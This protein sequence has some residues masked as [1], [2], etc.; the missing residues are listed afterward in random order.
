MNNINPIFE[1]LSGVDERHVP[2][3]TKK[4]PSKK[5]KIALI[6]VAAAAALSLIIGAS[7]PRSKHYGKSPVFY[8]PGENDVVW[9]Y[10]TPQKFTYPD[11]FVFEDWL[12][13]GE[14]ET[15]DDIPEMFGITP[16]V[17]DNFTIGDK[18]GNRMYYNAFDTGL[19]QSLS[20]D[21]YLYDK[22]LGDVTIHLESIYYS[23]V[24]FIETGN[25]GN[26]YDNVE[27]I[28]LK[29]GSSCVMWGDNAQ[30]VHE[31]VEYYI[32]IYREQSQTHDD[33]K[34]VLADLGVL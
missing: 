10:P 22:N 3:E 27:I 9:L 18:Y 14:L 34:Q 30:F 28:S 21:Y 13:S 20:I 2:I 26:S 29:D 33:I 11:Y 32:H 24:N 1:A 5:L 25:G 23:D 4:R 16:L 8:G 31:G 17:N 7:M 6:A 19:C 12:C 15:L